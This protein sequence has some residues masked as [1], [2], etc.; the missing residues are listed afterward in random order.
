MIKLNSLRQCAALPYRFRDGH[1]S[2]LLVTSIRTKRWVLPKGNIEPGLTARESAEFEALEEAGVVGAM[3]ARRTGTYRYRKSDEKSGLYQV[4]VFPLEVQ[5]ELDT[6]PESDLRNREWMRVEDAAARV[7]EPDLKD[8]LL[9][10][11]ERI[12]EAD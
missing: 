1:L 7:D 2:V 6:Y 12:Q 3:A 8:L 9:Q 10:F 4:L 11:A 5:R